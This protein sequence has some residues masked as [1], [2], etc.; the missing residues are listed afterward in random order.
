MQENDETALG[1]VGRFAAFLGAFALVTAYLTNSPTEILRRI[2]MQKRADAALLE[3]D[4][5]YLQ[6][7]A[8]WAEAIKIS[9]DK[10]V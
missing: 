3:Q 6:Y 4:P 2:E 8:R 7:K 1:D 5:V 9:Q 10:S